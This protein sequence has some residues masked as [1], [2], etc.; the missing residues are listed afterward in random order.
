LNFYI[1]ISPVPL[2]FYLYIVLEIDLI[3]LE[4]FPLTK[5]LIS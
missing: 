4:K 1:F 3:S 2:L 5:T